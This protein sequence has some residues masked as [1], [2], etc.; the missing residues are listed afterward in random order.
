MRPAAELLLIERTAIRPVLDAA[1]P[2]DFGLATVCD[3]WSVR[4]VIAHCAAALSMTGSGSLHGFSPAEN[5]QDVDERKTWEI[6]AVLDEL[7]ARYE[8]AIDLAAGALD[9]VGLGEWMHGG[10]IRDP[11]GATDAY[12]SPGVDLAL[13]LLIERSR[14]RAMTGVDLSIDGQ[15]VRFGSGDPL[16]RVETDLETFV[17]LCGGRR[18]DP[19]GYRLDGIE[20]SALDLFG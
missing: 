10:D 4:D 8:A 16:G 18:P 14:A 13:E 11:L 9:G 15:I 20:A 1:Q 5:Q 6:P 3:G 17:R 7:Y 2:S 12:T 19:Q